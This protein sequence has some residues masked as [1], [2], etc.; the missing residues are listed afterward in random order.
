MQKSQRTRGK[1][2]P[3]A[4]EAAGSAPALNRLIVLGAF[5]ALSL[6]GGCSSTPVAEYPNVLQYNPNTGYPAVGGPAWVDAH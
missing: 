3:K 5:L 2:S 1:A 6:L 4:E